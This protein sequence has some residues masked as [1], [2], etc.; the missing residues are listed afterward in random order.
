MSI[1]FSGSMDGGS[2]ARG[3]QSRM[4]CKRSKGDTKSC[5]RLTLQIVYVKPFPC[6][7]GYAQSGNWDGGKFA[8]LWNP[9]LALPG[10]LQNSLQT[11]GV[12]AAATLPLPRSWR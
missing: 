5:L 12:S 4:T 10:K 7:D 3:N 11:S 6:P 1:H 9:V 8:R 2:S